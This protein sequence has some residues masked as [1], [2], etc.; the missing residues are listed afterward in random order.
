MSPTVA[1]GLSTEPETNLGGLGSDQ[2]DSARANEGMSP[3]TR[4]IEQSP[5]INR[6]FICALSNKPLL[7]QL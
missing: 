1:T 5:E 2:Y 3:I 4:T 7:L 6:L